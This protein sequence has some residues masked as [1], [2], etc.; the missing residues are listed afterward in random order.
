MLLIGSS[1][2]GKTAL[3]KRLAGYPDDDPSFRGVVCPVAGL[4][5][6]CHLHWSEL[7]RPVVVW[8]ISGPQS[9]FLKKK[10]PFHL[11]LPPTSNFLVFV[12]S[13]AD[14]STFVALVDAIDDSYDFSFRPAFLVGTHADCATR[15]VTSDEIASFQRA[16]S[17][18][19][20]FEVST[21]EGLGI[22]SFRSAL[23]T[24]I[25]NFPAVHPD[26]HPQIRSS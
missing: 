22:D 3:I 18:H 14:P 12:F 5:D 21:T 16:H 20:F 8:D 24:A 15:L 25:N 19:H 10:D 4:I 6:F 11:G 1:G 23:F 13:L 26:L 2:V 7:T 17:I 9:G